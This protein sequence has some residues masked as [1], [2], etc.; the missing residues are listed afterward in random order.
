MKYITSVVTNLW[1]ISKTQYGRYYL[2]FFSFSEQFDKQYK[3]NPRIY[4]LSFFMQ[5]QNLNYPL[6]QDSLYCAPPPGDIVGQHKHTVY[7][8]LYV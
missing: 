7:T 4:K 2:I 8:I 1:V 3:M 5:I 6:A